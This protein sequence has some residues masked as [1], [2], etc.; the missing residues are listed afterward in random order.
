[1]PTII[2]L[3]DVGSWPADVLACLERNYQVLFGWETDQN[4]PSGYIYD[5]AIETLNAALQPYALVGWHCTRLTTDEISNILAQGLSLPDSEMLTRRIDQV[6]SAGLLSPSLAA[7]LKAKNLS[8]EPTRAGRLWFCFFRPALGRESG[9]N[10][11]FR[12]WGGEALYN[13]HER[14]PANSKALRAI[15]TPCIVEAEVPIRSLGGNPGLAFKVARHYLIHRGY[16]TTE[17]TDHEDRIVQP[18]PA[19]CVRQIHLFPEPRFLELTD[20]E[21]WREPLDP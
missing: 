17:P 3:D 12:C 10:R 15:G 18:L 2:D 14:H 20:C 4:R 11:F 19:S 7:T 16:R 5:R 13:S 1:L 6:V 9:I 21:S 8:H